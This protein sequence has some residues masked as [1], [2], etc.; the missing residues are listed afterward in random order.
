MS[1]RFRCVDWPDRSRRKMLENLRNHLPWSHPRR[2]VRQQNRHRKKKTSPW[3]H[4]RAPKEKNALELDYS[5]RVLGSRIIVRAVLANNDDKRSWTKKDQNRI[6]QRTDNHHPKIKTVRLLPKS[7]RSPSRRWNAWG[8]WKHKR[9]ATNR[10]TWRQLT[11]KVQVRRWQVLNFPK[12][13]MNKTQL[14]PRTR[15]SLY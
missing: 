9:T 6:L 5:S 3:T 13:T 10:R 4:T 15:Q 12:I 14:S 2:R 11:K 8:S 1:C 7:L